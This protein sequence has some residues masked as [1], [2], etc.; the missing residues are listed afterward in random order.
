MFQKCKAKLHLFQSCFK[1]IYCE[2]LV[3]FWWQILLNSLRFMLR[4]QQNNV[5]TVWKQFQTSSFGCLVIIHLFSSA[6]LYLWVLHTSRST[7]ELLL[8]FI[9]PLKHYWV[10][11]HGA[12]PQTNELDCHSVLTFTTKH[13]W[14]LKSHL[15]CVHVIRL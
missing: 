11:V 4:N 1:N 5:L 8:V 14:S 13:T 6:G 12:D 9:F 15:K 3:L 2:Y 10:S 7:G